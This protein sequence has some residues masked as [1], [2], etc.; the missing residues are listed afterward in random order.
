MWKRARTSHARK[1]A[2]WIALFVEQGVDFILGCGFFRVRRALQPDRANAPSR[3]FPRAD[4][5]PYLGRRAAIDS[6]P[7]DAQNRC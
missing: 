7:Q 4:S 1:G 6:E 5:P 3:R 2:V